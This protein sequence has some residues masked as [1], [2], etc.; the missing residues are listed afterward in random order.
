MQPFGD[1][2]FRPSW[3][4]KASRNVGPVAAQAGRRRVLRVSWL[5]AKAQAESRRKRISESDPC[6]S[7]E[8]YFP[9]SRYRVKSVFG[10]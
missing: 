8:E 6:Y 2:S 4:W 1:S 9:S 3:L 5:W 10:Q 7:S